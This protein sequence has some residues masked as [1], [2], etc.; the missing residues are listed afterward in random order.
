MVVV[1]FYY[2]KDD[3]MFI[4]ED[5]KVVYDIYKY[6]TPNDLFLF[7]LRKGTSQI[8]SKTDKNVVYELVYQ[9]FDEDY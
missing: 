5:G 8:H 3:N 1:S 7:K 9:E 2:L 6:V 4:D